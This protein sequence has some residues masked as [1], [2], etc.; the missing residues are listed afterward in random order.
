MLAFIISFAVWEIDGNF[1]SSLY[2]KGEKMYEGFAN[3]KGKN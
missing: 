2:I 1:S 3:V